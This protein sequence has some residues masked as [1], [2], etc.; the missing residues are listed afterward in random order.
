MK[1]SAFV[2]KRSTFRATRHFEAH[3]LAVGHVVP[4]RGAQPREMAPP[5]SSAP[6]LLGFAG[7]MVGGGERLD[8]RTTKIGGVPD[9]P[10]PAAAAADGDP[11]GSLHHDPAAPPAEMT[12]CA[13]CGEVMALVAQAHARTSAP[14][15]VAGAEDE[16][17]QLSTSKDF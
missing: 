12:A 2:T 14:E 7:R 3:F 17:L 4:L 11:D 16:K 8:H 13:R 1:N 9:W 6:V 15:L 10:P 5:T